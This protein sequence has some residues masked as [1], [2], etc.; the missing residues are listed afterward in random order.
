LTG[1]GG[2]GKTRLAIEVAADLEASFEDGVVFVSLPAVRDPDLVI[3]EIAHALDLRELAGRP[4]PEQLAAALRSK[5]LLLVL[6][7]FEQVV[8][9]APQVTAL[10]VAC[11]RLKVLV[12]SR[13]VL[14]VT[15]EQDF[16]VPSL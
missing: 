4:P 16:P 1:P 14:R 13:A 11:P 3:S 9:A 2:V 6:D 7:N 10:L 5:H 15:G 8:E 12:T